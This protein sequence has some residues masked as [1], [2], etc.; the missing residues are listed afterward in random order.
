MMKLH[1][2][3]S[4]RV[5]L[6]SGADLTPTAAKAQGLLALLATAPNGERSRTWLQC[7]LWSDRGSL[8]A[9]ASLRQALVQIRRCFGATAFVL[10]ANRQ[11]IRLDLSHVEVVRT[12]GLE[13]LEGIDVRDQEFERWLVDT[14]VAD[15]DIAPTVRGRASSLEASQSCGDAWTI[16]ILPRR[17]GIDEIDWMAQIFSDGLAQNLR[18]LF[19][20]NVAVCN[21]LPILTSRL[22]AVHVQ[23]SRVS[24]GWVGAR[25]SLEHPRSGRQAWAGARSVPARG[26]PPVESA[27]LMA[28]SNQ[29]VEAIGDTMFLEAKADRDD[30]D[31]LCRRAIRQVFLMRP[32]SAVAADRLL[33]Q[34]YEMKPRGL[35]LAWRAQV[36]AIQRVEKHGGDNAMLRDAGAEFCARALEIEPNNSMV[37]ATVAN[38]YGH[39]LRDVD[40]PLYLAKRSVMLNPSNPMGWWALSSANVYA[41]NI[42]A[43]YENAVAARQL[44]LTSPH[45]FWWDNQLFGA[46]LI[47]GNLDEARRLAEA[48]TA[49]NADFRPPF[50]YLVALYANAG[51]VE[52]AT[53]AA[54][55]LKEIEPDFSADR[56]M[57]DREY[58][59]S[60]I[61]R[62][63]GLKV[64]RLRAII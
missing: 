25:V 33:A 9:A 29:M 21:D 62:A 58:P 41:G 39:L 46:A 24:N 38:T 18:E 8:Q 54:E 19:S 50:R 47:T 27:E 48:C 53:R 57:R 10:T 49:Q 11:R 61:H 30:P 55:R 36:K 17:T 28:L 51:R 13:F 52:D 22:W 14:R 35:Y 34:A 64:D 59:A 60:L 16:A 3:G 42:A 4:F 20:V 44:A 31:L 7:K 32:D 45:R 37:L 56:L 23:M 43:S 12:A 40:R 63:P 5:E 26:A 15:E 6:S 2:N 1:L